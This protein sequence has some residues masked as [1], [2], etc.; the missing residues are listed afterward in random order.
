VTLFGGNLWP[1]VLIIAVWLLSM[2]ALALFVSLTVPRPPANGEAQWDLRKTWQELT[3]LIKLGFGLGV[4]LTL[5][6]LFRARAATIHLVSG[7]CRG[8]SKTPWQAYGQVRRKQLRVFW[9]SA[10]VNLAGPPTFGLVP[11]LMELAFAPAY[12]VAVLED[13]K[14]LD[15]IKRG[16]ALSGGTYGRVVLL[17]LSYALLVMALLW[18]LVPL[19]HFFARMVEITGTPWPAR[20]GAMLWLLLLGLL[21]QIYLVALTVNF[22][23]LQ[24]VEEPKP[25]GGIT[26]P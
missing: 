26:L 10:A 13:R 1:F 25:L 4:L 19:L 14:A 21:H 15:A 23:A 17:V 9:L 7:L 6:V 12:P 22:H 11:L 16:L 8:E 5:A 2:V 20:V 24:A 18:G 3:P